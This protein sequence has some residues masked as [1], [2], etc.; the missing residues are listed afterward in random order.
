MFMAFMSLIVVMVS[1]TYTYLQ[2]QVVYIKNV[3]LFL[4][5]SYLNK[6]V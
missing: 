5:Q 4:C 2:T 6:V 1:H 3:K